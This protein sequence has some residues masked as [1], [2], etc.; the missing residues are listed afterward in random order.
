MFLTFFIHTTH[1]GH[2][3]V[4]IP[5]F[6]QFLASVSRHFEKDLSLSLAPLPGTPYLYLSEKL[7]VFQLSKKLKTQLCEKY[8]C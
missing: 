4:L 6:L 8:F 1:L 5:L 7:G 3:T 2:C